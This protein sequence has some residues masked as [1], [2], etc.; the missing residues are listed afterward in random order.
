MQGGFEQYFGKVTRTVT[1]VERDG[2]ILRKVSLARAFATDVDDLWDAVTNQQ[3]LERWFLPVTG[4][5]E[6]GGRFQLKGNAGGDILVCE[7]PSHLGVT[8]EFGGGKSWVD[9]FLA[10]DSRDDAK[11]TLEHLCPVDDFWEQYGPGAVGVGW[12]LGLI[13]LA[14]HFDP[15]APKFDEEALATSKEG[16]AYIYGCSDDWGRA[17]VVAGAKEAAAIAQAKK[18][19]AFYTGES[20]GD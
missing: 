2:K 14:A 6:K 11:L 13:G 15:E 18:T 10:K 7:P 3:R 16:K 19:A 8:W 17:N 20:T 1:D 4:N 12:D 9:V 5:L